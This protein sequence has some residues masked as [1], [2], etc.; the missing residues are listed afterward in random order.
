MSDAKRML[1]EQEDKAN[2]QRLNR[3]ITKVRGKIDFAL[4]HKQHPLYVRQLKG[5]LA[6]L[7]EIRNEYNS[8]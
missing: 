6:R 4:T 3:N 1:E 7:L 2:R 8:G 5:E